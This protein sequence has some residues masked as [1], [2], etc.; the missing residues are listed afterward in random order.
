MLKL[1]DKFFAFLYVSF[2]H[3]TNLRVGYNQNTPAMLYTLMQQ[4]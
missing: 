2:A 1:I 4:F 3:S